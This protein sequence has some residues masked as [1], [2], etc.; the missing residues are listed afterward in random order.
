MF[1]LRMIDIFGPE[2]KLKIKKKD[3]YKTDI[4]GFFTFIFAGL[5]SLAIVSKL[6][7]LLYYKKPVLL[8][9]NQ[10]QF[11]TSFKLTSE[12]FAFSVFNQNYNTLIPNYEKRFTF[13]LEVFDNYNGIYKNSTYKIQRCEKETIERK[14]NH[15]RVDKTEYWCLP[16]DVSI[17]INGTHLYGNF[18]NARLSVDF[19]I[20]G[21]HDRNDCLNIS[22]TKASLK[23]VVMNMI[24]DD[25]YSDYE[26]YNDPFISTYHIENVI[27]NMNTFSRKI[28]YF[29]ELAYETDYGWIT[30][31]LRTNETK[32]F[33]Y[34]E[35]SFTFDQ[36]T[37]T[38]FS[39]MIV[40]S[41]NKDLYERSYV[42]IQ[43]IFAYIGGFISIS[44]ILLEII[45]KFLIYPG[46][47]HIFYKKYHLKKIPPVDISINLLNV[48]NK[49][50]NNNN[51]INSRE[52]NFNSKLLQKQNSQVSRV[53]LV[54]KKI[55]FKLKKFTIWTKLFRI[56]FC[57]WN[58]EKKN[59]FKFLDKLFVKKFSV[60]HFIKLSRKISLIEALLFQRYQRE[61]IK[62]V[63]VPKFEKIYKSYEE[64]MIK[65]NLNMTNPINQN[66][67][68]YLNNEFD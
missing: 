55:P 13:Y 65:L 24:F 49:S 33:D 29:K 45:C 64:S 39:I 35:Y 53:S 11:E 3:T 16:K 40:N 2:L 23:N 44:K 61:L 8:Y 26:N 30:R 27:S 18:T 60:E 46:V 10:K 66:L 67:K 22:D 57:F 6:L 34:S 58:K 7:E 42:K 14:K 32:A 38:I 48:P 51:E 15:L 52:N 31:V 4:G 21:T 25:F 17:Q 47:L 59:Q 43:G 28:F 1:I 54:F 63:D 62:Y 50:I 12:N 5:V 41:N 56:F 36:N 9:K 37:N 19:C 68:R 20:N